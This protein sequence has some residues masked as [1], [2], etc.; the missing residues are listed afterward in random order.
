M[1]TMMKIRWFAENEL[2]L[3]T[4]SL[5]VPQLGHEVYYKGIT[6]MITSVY[7]DMSRIQIDVTMMEI[8]ITVTP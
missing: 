3:T 4:T 1:T 6:Y 7:W 5:M 8:E 2:V